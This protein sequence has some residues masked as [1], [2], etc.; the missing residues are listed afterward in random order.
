M[1]NIIS[2][3]TSTIMVS[4]PSVTVT[5]VVEIYDSNQLEVVTAGVGT[6]IL[7]V[8]VPSDRVSVVVDVYDSVQVEVVNLTPVGTSIITVAV[9]SAPGNVVSRKVRFSPCSRGSNNRHWSF[10]G[11]RFSGI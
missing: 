5:V 7:T 4:V 10:N 3:G 8:S 1:V 6:S 2:V 11:Y 9:A